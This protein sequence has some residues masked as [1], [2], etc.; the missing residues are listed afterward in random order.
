MSFSFN[1]NKINKIMI[2]YKSQ[3]LFEIIYKKKVINY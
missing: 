2:H 1:T 3:K